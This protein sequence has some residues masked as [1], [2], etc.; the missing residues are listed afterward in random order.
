[1][2]SEYRINVATTRPCIAN[3]IANM[4]PLVFRLEQ[5]KSAP[6]TPQPSKR[7]VHSPSQPKVPQSESLTT[8][9]GHQTYGIHGT[10]TIQKEHP[11]GARSKGVPI[12][13]STAA[14]PHR[15]KR[16][17][18]ALD[19]RRPAMQLSRHQ[20]RQGQAR[21]SC[22][23]ILSYQHPTLPS[24]RYQVWT[25]QRE[26]EMGGA[27]GWTESPYVRRPARRCDWF[28]RSHLLVRCISCTMY[29]SSCN[30]TF[31]T[32][33]VESFEAALSVSYR[34]VYVE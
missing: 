34:G 23:L 1:M 27:K 6:S 9:A 20:A 2:V 13:A 31:S 15:T 8:N 32:S 11:Q 25:P 22:P 21:T 17:N 18:T 28:C 12:H 7:D 19:S 5:D 14:L 4:S 16:T 3:A 33:G 30:M 24:T 26:P 10:S 29:K